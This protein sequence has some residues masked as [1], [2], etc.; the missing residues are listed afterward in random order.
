MFKKT[1]ISSAIAIMA[2][3]GASAVTSVI[4]P[5]EVSAASSVGQKTNYTTTQYVKSS[6]GALNVRVSYS[7]TSKLVV[8]LK[9]NQEVKTKYKI[10][11]KDGS[12]WVYGTSAGKTGWMNEKYLTKTKPVTKV[13]SGAVS[14]SAGS[15]LVTF[16][17]KLSGIKYVWGGTTLRGFDC[18]GFTQYVFK[19]VTGKTIP[20]V[21]ASQYSA[22]KKITKNEAKP[23]DLVFFSSNGNSVTHVAIYAGDNKILHSTSGKGVNLGKLYDGYWNKRLVGFGRI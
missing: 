22:S 13:T 3:T 2:I 18:S 7:S 16:G 6:D 4:S 11:L 12:T 21:A 20:R 9:N 1:V 8:T 15:L 5:T 14:A 10:K 17:K 23:G 19:N